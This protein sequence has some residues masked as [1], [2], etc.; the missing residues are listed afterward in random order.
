MNS[1][2]EL[3]GKFRSWPRG[4]VA[5]LRVVVWQ[6][7]AACAE[8]FHASAAVLAWED[9]EEPW[10]IIARLSDSGLDWREEVAGEVAPIVDPA[11]SDSPFLL[12]SGHITNAFGAQQSRSP[13]HPRIHDR[14]NAEIK[15]VI[16]IRG[17]TME[18]FIFVLDPQNR[19]RSMLV[20]SEVIG[21]L[22]EDRMDAVAQ[23]R[24]GQREA[25]AEERLR[26]ARDLHDGLL[27]S[28]TGVVLQLET[29]HDILDREPDRARRMLTEAQGI[30]MADQRELRA[31]VEELRP[32]RRRV[33]AVFDFPARIE[34]LRSR[35]RQQ[36]GIELVIDAA[37]V[38]PNISK[39]LGQET[40]RLIQEAVVNSAK[41]GRASQ[42]DV[43][44][45]TADSRI[46]IE[47]TDNGTGFPFHGRM[48]LDSIREK[49]IGPAALAERVASLNGDLAVESSDHGAR[50]EISFPL[51]FSGA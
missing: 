17:E 37:G 25:V 20:L 14:L 51:G 5:D 39:Y 40:F 31:F 43:R 36:W 1:P 12:E 11:L 30:I 13:I 35:F 23:Y 45:R 19:D 33:E 29:I 32:R 15:L 26:V 50:L 27:Q 18:G 7:L 3:C 2:E 42:V 48:S 34:D 44:L 8:L 46:R 16:P 49:G 24:A 10:L 9:R 21:R 28:F 4:F 6:T 38:D 22:V 47:V 41:H